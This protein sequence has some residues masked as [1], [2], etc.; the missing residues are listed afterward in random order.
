MTPMKQQLK[1]LK[2]GLE[3][4]TTMNDQVVT[5]DSVRKYA[6]TILA[7]LDRAGT[8]IPSEEELVR[9]V[10]DTCA[11]WAM[12]E[13]QLNDDMK[14]GDPCYVAVGDRYYEHINTFVEVL[15]GNDYPCKL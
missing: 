13:M 15:N 4:I 5:V 3:V 14:K 2:R 8:T 10:K 1:L 12:E 11:A 6:E 7:Q 9:H